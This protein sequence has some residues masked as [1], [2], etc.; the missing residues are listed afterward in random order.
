M[1]GDAEDIHHN[2]ALLRELEAALM[3]MTP[4]E[5]LEFLDWLNAREVTPCCKKCC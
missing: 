2:D 4:K 1:I 3:K 5:R